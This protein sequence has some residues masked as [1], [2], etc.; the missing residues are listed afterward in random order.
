[1]NAFSKIIGYETITRELERIA[2]V[3][4]DAAPYA[5]LGVKPPRG[6][7]LHGDPGVGKSLMASCVIEASGRPAFICRK[8][9][10]DGAFVDAIRETFAAAAES[11]PS[12]V[13]LDDLDKFA[14][15][16]KKCCNEEEYVTVQACI[17]EVRD[18]DV[19]VLATANDVDDLPGSLLRVGRFDRVIRVPTP[20]G[21]DAVRIAAHYLAGKP[22]LS[23]ADAAKAA[24]AVARLM[25]GRSC[26]ELETAVNEAGLLAGQERLDHVSMNCLLRACLLVTHGVRPDSVVPHRPDDPT[27]SRSRIVR[28]AYHEAGHAAVAEL[29]A[30]GSVSLVCIHEEEAGSSGFTRY[31]PVSGRSGLQ[32][33]TDIILRSLGGRAAVEVRFNRLELGV[34]H[35]LLYARRTLNELMDEGVYG[36]S[37][38]DVPR[39]PDS[40]A[41]HA[42]REAVI[43]SELERFYLRAKELL[44]ENRAFLDA[45][46]AAL[47]DRGILT[48][49]E[50]RE[51]KSMCGA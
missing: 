16:D 41:L 15:S 10:P 20:A 42:R 34:G 39:Q 24:G 36:F 37:L 13:F 30:P 14:N 25:A 21:E 23:G 12:I 29:L 11:A 40:D 51:I 7:L 32:E 8:N 49:E 31:C 6:L 5:R 22:G 38:L 48:G 4:R 28:A 9:K 35:D 1:M 44:T 18:N 50:L 43:T 26:A 27:D 19:F 45:L 3:L 33:R 2:D 17:D 46:A 47:L